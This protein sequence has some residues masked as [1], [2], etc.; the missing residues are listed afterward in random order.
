MDL[1]TI[2]FPKK[3]NDGYKIEDLNP[4]KHNE[5]YKIGTDLIFPFM[6][7]HGEKIRKPRK[8]KIQKGLAYLDAVTKINPEN[9]SALWVKGK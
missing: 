7:I 4:E 5:Y 6:Q 1:L 9:W 2:L 8:Q 3:N